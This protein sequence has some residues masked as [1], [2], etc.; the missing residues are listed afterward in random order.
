MGAGRRL[1]ESFP[2]VRSWRRPS[3]FQGDPVMGLRSL[4]DGYVP[5]ILDVSQLDRKL[6]V[7]NAEAVAGMQA[8]LEQEGIF[9]GISSGA[10]R[11]TSPGGS[12]TS[13]TR[14]SSSR[15]SPT[16]A[17]STCPRRSGRLTT[18]SAAMEHA[19]WW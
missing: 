16:A 4:E 11:C 13:S 10:R 17:G 6:L 19:L 7:S 15:S 9:A 8:L 12:P 5:P 3:R 2:D 14:A 1:R 18:W